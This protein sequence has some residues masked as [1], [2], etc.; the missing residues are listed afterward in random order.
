[1]RHPRGP[2]RPHAARQCTQERALI[3]QIERRGF[4]GKEVR[5]LDALAKRAELALR[6]NRE[7][8]LFWGVGF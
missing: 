4:E 2:L 1:L 8:A 7:P 5:F 6:R 3:D